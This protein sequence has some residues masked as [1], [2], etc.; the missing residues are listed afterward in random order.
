MY[1]MMVFAKSELSSLLCDCAIVSL[2]RWGEADFACQMLSNSV[3]LAI[4]EERP[5]GIVLSTKRVRRV[6]RSMAGHSASL[7]R[8]ESFQPNLSTLPFNFI[9]NI[10]VIVEYQSTATPISMH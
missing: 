1:V 4:E 8:Q 10:I 6:S 2:I 9:I 3:V 7:D 5:E